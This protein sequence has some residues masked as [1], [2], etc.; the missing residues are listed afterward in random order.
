VN[1]I[2]KHIDEISKACPNQKYV[3]AGHSQGAVVVTSS[4]PKI[5]QASKAKLLAVTVFGAPPCLAE[6]KD[7]CK[8]YC[9]AG[10]DVSSKNLL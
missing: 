10:D 4:I 9:N 6:V 5:P 7:K 1:D 2:L 8:S 3:L